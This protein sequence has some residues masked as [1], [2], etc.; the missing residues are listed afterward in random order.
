VPKQKE[1]IKTVAEELKGWNLKELH[2]IYREYGPWKF[3]TDNLTLTLSDRERRARYEVDLERIN[4][5][6]E[7]LDWVMQVANK[8]WATPDDLG[9]LVRALNAIFHPQATLCSF[10][11]EKWIDA[12]VHL[13]R[14][15][16]PNLIDGACPPKEEDDDQDDDE[17]DAD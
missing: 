10:G 1:R 12:S 11:S 14:N 16:V 3:A 9:W 6:G 5:S 15:V 7:M 17:I 4:T 8:T 2:P 13:K